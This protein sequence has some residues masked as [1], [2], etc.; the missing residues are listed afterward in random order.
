MALSRLMS[1]VRMA[2]GIAALF[3]A[4]VL[5]WIGFTLIGDGNFQTEGSPA[6]AIVA[7]IA[8]TAPIGAL[9]ALLLGIGL[10]RAARRKY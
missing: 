1:G 2:L 6:G 8:Y 9:F 4:A 5:G 10:V 7:V 3:A